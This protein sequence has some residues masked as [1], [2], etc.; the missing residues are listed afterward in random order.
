MIMEKNMCVPE[1]I[2]NFVKSMNVTDCTWKTS[3]SICNVMTN[4]HPTIR[5][6]LHDKFYFE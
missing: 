6:Q 2:K 4:L 1:P 5:Y 3:C